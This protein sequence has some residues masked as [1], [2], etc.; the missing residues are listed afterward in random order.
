VCEQKQM[1]LLL[2]IFTS[3]YAFLFFFFFF[4]FYI[5]IK[6]GNPY[7]N[8]KLVRLIRHLLIW[9]SWFFLLTVEFKCFVFLILINCN[10]TLIRLWVT[11]LI[12]IKFFVMFSMQ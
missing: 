12:N 9:L 4:L 5:I 11:E 10:L 6:N 8:F 2:F 7:K 3:F 1:S